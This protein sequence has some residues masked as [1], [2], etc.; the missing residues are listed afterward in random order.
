MPQFLKKPVPLKLG[1]VLRKQA[2]TVN[3]LLRHSLR[4]KVKLLRKTKANFYYSDIED[5]EKVVVTSL[6]QDRVDL[7]FMKV[8]FTLLKTEAAN[9]LGIFRPATLLRK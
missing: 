8:G 1:S 4:F 6:M 3:F 5:S 2:K 9:S 7:V